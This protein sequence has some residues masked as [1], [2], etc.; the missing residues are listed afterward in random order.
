MK[1]VERGRLI[2][3]VQTNC[4]I[5]D[6]RHAAD[7]TLCTYLLQMRE[8]FRW[9]QGSAFGSSIDREALGS[10]IAEREAL[11]TSL[12]DKG[13]ARLPA[14]GLPDGLDPFDVVAINSRL[15]PVGLLY[16]AGLV[17]AERP[18]F[19]LAELHGQT[20]H[21]EIELLTAGRELARGL[22]APPAALGN[23]NERQAIVIRRESLARWCWEK[24]ETFMLRQPAGSA[25]HAVVEAYGLDHD[26]EAAMPRWLDEQGEAVL[27][28]ELGEHRAGQWLGPAWSAMRIGLASRRADLYARAVRDHLADLAV[29]LPTLLD[30]QAAASLHF[31]FATYDGIREALF[32]SL[33]S[34]YQAWREGDGGLA[35]RRATTR[36]HAH[37]TELAAKVMALHLRDGAQAGPAIEGLLTA[38]EAI[39]SG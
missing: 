17:G 37:F 2:E 33:Q 26:F 35:L 25:F 13:Y 9:E 12:E 24:F 14:L 20:R 4:H 39:C 6:A 32:P 1:A 3:A 38:P 34:D 23:W 7:M 28:H 11:W 5:A 36:G 19:F 30:R 29:T 8:F 22:I 10:W 16:G 15:R 18:V 21:E 31:W 27:L